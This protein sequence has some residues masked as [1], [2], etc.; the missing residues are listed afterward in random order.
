MQRCYD[1]LNPSAENR[2]R[3]EG[4]LEKNRRRKK[5]TTMRAC[6]D[7]VDRASRRAA[8]LSRCAAAAN[9]R[10]D[11]GWHEVKRASEEMVRAAAALRDASSNVRVIPTAKP[12]S[13][14]RPSAKRCV[15]CWGVKRTDRLRCDAC[16]M[17]N[18]QQSLRR[19]ARHAR[20]GRCYCG[21]E[22]HEDRRSC[23]RCLEG[24]RR[25]HRKRRRWRD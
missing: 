14:Q 24:D 9:G 20:L 8:A 18:R 1:C 16:L 6:L 21:R 19:R 5:D 3:C 23:E 15:D 2:S 25:R 12:V 22:R 17:K 4:C 7:Q 13:A 10:Y 11:P